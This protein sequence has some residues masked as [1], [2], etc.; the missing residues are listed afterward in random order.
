MG[1]VYRATDTKLAREVAIKVVPASVLVDADRM[2][3]FAREAR[4]LASLNH[5]N[6]AS[7]YGVEESALVMELVEGPTL[8]ERIAAG[9]IP[10]EE[11]RL[12]VDQL[13]DGL[14]YAHERGV[15]HR[16][17]KP[18]NIKVTPD[19]RVKILDFGLAKALSSEVVQSDPLS[20]PTLTIRATA[21]GM[22]MGTA[23]YM[24]P[25]QARGQDVDKRADIWSFGA[26]LYEMLTRQQLFAGDTVSDSIAYVLTRQFELREVPKQFEPLLAR[27]L[28]RDRRRRLRDIGDARWLLEQSPATSSSTPANRSWRWAAACGALTLIA[29]AFGFL[30]RRAAPARPAAVRFAVDSNRFLHLLLSADGQF[31]LQPNSCYRTMPP[32]GR[33]DRG[34]EP[35]RQMACLFIRRP[36]RAVRRG[37]SRVRK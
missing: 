30:W 19:G 4:V 32:G 24:A 7:I 34:L 20:S 31:L 6:I 8:E 37:L 5:P 16:D 25:E 27:C 12:I 10:V 13:I 11:A 36:G 23:A 35:G 26:V 1:E 29:G 2:A 9:P 33:P 17:L 22:I 18:A 15:V 14:E 28:V 3:R 21:T